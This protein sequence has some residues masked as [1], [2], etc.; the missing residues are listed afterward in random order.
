LT[1]AHIQLIKLK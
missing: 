1:N